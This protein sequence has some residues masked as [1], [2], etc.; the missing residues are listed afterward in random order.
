MFGECEVG[1]RLGISPDERVTGFR[2]VSPNPPGIVAVYV[3]GRRAPLRA[4]GEIPEELHAALD[5]VSYQF[6]QGE[7]VGPVAAGSLPHAPDD[8]LAQLLV[9]MEEAE[10]QG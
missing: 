2:I 10:E 1:E 6:P 9:L 5:E 7:T 8:A 4:Q 3:M